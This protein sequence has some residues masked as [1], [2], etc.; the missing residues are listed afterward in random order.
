MTVKQFF[1]FAIGCGIE[2]DPRGEKSVRKQLA[3]EKEEYE[4]LPSE[5]KKYYDREK[6]SNPYADSRILSNPSNGKVKNILCGIDID[7]GEILLA[8]LLSRRGKKIDLVV[9]H[10]PVGFSY[11]NFYDVMKMQAEIQ[12]GWG[13]PINIAEDLLDERMSKVARSVMPRNHTKTVDAAKILGIALLNLHTPADNHVASYLGKIFSKKTGLRLKDVVKILEEIPEYERARKNF[14]PSPAIVVGK[15]SRSAGRVVV[16]MTGGTEGA[17]ESIAKMAS[18]GVGTIVGM[19]FS[20]NHIKKA[21]ESHIN[22]VIAGHISSDTLGLNLLFDKIEK[23]FGKLNF[24][25]CGGFYRIS[26][27]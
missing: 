6:L 9:S 19:H 26:R 24:I 7:V 21:K 3:M 20:E 22:I 27:N 16:D 13:V 8:D 17:E 1:D 10:H 4:N 23:K 14:L 11:S 25:S 2:A 5:R 18:A 15:P 12:S